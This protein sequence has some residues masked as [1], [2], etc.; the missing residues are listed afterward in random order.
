MLAPTTHSS[1]QTDVS[2]GVE[3]HGLQANTQS[4]PA[5]RHASVLADN[6]TS[7]SEYGDGSGRDM[8]QR[9]ARK[10]AATLGAEEDDD[11]DDED[12]DETAGE[13]LSAAVSPKATAGADRGKDAGGYDQRRSERFGDLS[14]GQKRR[15]CKAIFKDIERLTDDWKGALEYLLT[16][17]RKGRQVGGKAHRDTEAVDSVLKNINMMHSQAPVKY[18]SAVLALVA[19]HFSINDLKRRKFKFSN[20]QFTHARRKHREDN[21]HLVDYVRAVPPSRA[22]VS[23][24]CKSIMVE[25]LDRYSTAPSAGVSSAGSGKTGGARLL[26]KTKREIYDQMVLDHPSIKISRAKF[27]DLCPK[28]YKPMATAAASLQKPHGSSSKLPA[29]PAHQKPSTATAAAKQ[30]QQQPPQSTER[31]AP[32]AARESPSIDAIAAAAAAA[33]ASTVNIDLPFPMPMPMSSSWLTDSTGWLADN[34]LD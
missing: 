1:E 33:A 22:P 16:Q 31:N 32:A 34:G 15:I 27:Y 21:F 3:D 2:S 7:S 17:T 26:V 12:E 19:P 9:A 4:I 14:T 28:N 20:D 8:G 11:D 6:D 23:D 18:K 29:T 24:E 5:K 25:Y 13:E 10:R 30:R